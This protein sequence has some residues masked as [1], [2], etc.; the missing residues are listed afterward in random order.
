MQ[1]IGKDPLD[2]YDKL[3]DKDS[4][5]E[6]NG[7][8]LPK[9]QYLQSDD[10]KNNSRKTRKRVLDEGLEEGEGKL[11]LTNI[12]LGVVQKLSD[13]TGLQC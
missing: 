2:M 12:Q 3:N 1:H 9:P 7:D 11:Q 10:N 6:R 4:E 8:E 5:E 13:F